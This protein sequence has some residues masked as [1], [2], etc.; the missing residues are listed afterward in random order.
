M[1]SGKL[2]K[3]LGKVEQGAWPGLNDEEISADEEGWFQVDID[4]NKG[5]N[6]IKIEAH[7]SYGRSRVKYLRI[8]VE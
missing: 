3:I 5:L 2:I 8:V 1:S 6:V 4:L 7:K